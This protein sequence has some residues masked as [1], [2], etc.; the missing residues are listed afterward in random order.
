MLKFIVFF[1]L[2][3]TNLSA[4]S[5][6]DNI[7]SRNTPFEEMECPIQIEGADQD[8]DG[9][10]DE[11]DKCPDTPCNLNVNYEGCPYKIDITLDRDRDGI[12]NHFDKC[13]DTIK[14]FAVNRDGCPICSCATILFQIFSDEISK[15]SRREIRNFVKAVNQ[16]YN[17]QII[18]KSNAYYKSGEEYNSTL[19]NQRIDKLSDILE[20]LGVHRNRIYTE[21]IVPQESNSSQEILAKNREMYLSINYL[22]Y[23]ADD[24]DK[25]G[26]FDSKDKCLGTGENII[27]DDFG[28]PLNVELDI[29]FKSNSSKLA[30]YSMKLLKNFTRYILENGM[31]EIY[32]RGYTDNKENNSIDLSYQR[33]KII[34]DKL[35]E[36]GVNEYNINL[37]YYGDKNSITPN[38]TLKDKARNRRVELRTKNN[39]NND[40]GEYWEN[41][42]NKFEK[43]ILNSKEEN[44]INDI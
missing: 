4:L 44:I 19:S 36:F 26:V 34:R 17:S 33:A 41:R 6:F 23:N 25:D 12:L 31:N 20:F 35:I 7:N 5:V 8:R 14:G 38:I 3:F 1:L 9:I 37:S 15:R 29:H 32:I 39:S 27:V 13:P 28:C 2:F 18:I 10:S 40:S 11:I 22:D 30:K 43:F 42:A 16:N 21:N 24:S